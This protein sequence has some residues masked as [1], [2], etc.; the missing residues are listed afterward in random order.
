MKIRWIDTS[1]FEIVTD[2]NERIVTDPFI[3]EC[4]NNPI[5]SDEVEKMDYI[6]ITHTHFD[7]ITQ[8]DKYYEL[9]Q[10]KILCS[11]MSSMALL[12]AFD[13]SGQCM[14]GMDHLESLDFGN[15][16]ITRI[17][18]QHSIPSRKERH[19]VRE[20]VIGWQLPESLDERYNNLMPSGYTDFSNFYIETKN[21]T[22]ILFWGGGVTAEQINQAKDLRPDI[23][24]IQI[25]SNPNKDIVKLIETVGAN[26]VI[27]H[28]HDTYYKSKDVDAMMNELKQ[29]IE[30][31]LPS[32]KFISLK[33]GKWYKYEKNITEN[34]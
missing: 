30:S 14:F 6:L 28:H 1:C 22:R 17:S 13:L 20:S 34:D 3:D 4:D 29:D 32:T 8:L 7:H 25:P 27:P 16:K 26:L 15:T 11:T 33:P 21:N 12:N 2:E 19:L 5:S 10:P 24:L 31:S 23:L 9:Y 18:A